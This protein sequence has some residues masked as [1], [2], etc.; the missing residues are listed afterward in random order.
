[1]KKLAKKTFE[2]VDDVVCDVC[3]KSCKDGLE[4]I[5][6]ASISA[7]WGYT[8]KKDGDQYELDICENCFDKLIQFLNDL[9][10]S[11]IKPN[12]TENII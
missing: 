9:K 5:E 2:V 10:G 8:S 7:Y 1:M 11:E 6:S 4:N 12:S 3:S